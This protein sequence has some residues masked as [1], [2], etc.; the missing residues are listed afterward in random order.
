MTDKLKRIY[1]FCKIW[2]ASIIIAGALVCTLLAKLYWAIHL[3]R[4]D[5]YPGWI[6]ADIPVLLGAELLCSLVC[7]FW[8]KNWAARSSFIFAA[9]ICTW[10]VINAGWLIATGT[11]VL[12]AVLAPLFFDPLGRFAIIGNHLAGKPL[13][14]AALLVPSGI[15]LTFFFSVLIKPAMPQLTK[16]H[17]QIRLA[18]YVILLLISGVTAK[19]S[20]LNTDSK[21]FAELR[22]NSQFKAVKSIFVNGRKNKNNGNSAEKIRTALPAYE[23]PLP[24]RTDKYAGKYNVVIVVLESI[25]PGQAKIFN[26]NGA[27]VPFLSKMARR[28]FAFTNC[29]TVA[30]HTTKALFAIHTGL[31]PSTSQ[32]YIEA[33]VQEKNYQSIATILKTAGYRTAFFQSAEGAF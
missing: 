6:V 20:Q 28:G 5:L 27:N 13:I 3:G 8:Q 22:Y 32:D 31:Y 17:I 14:A 30:T 19:I 26:H 4:V 1:A 10:S 16:K 12:P 21:I 18:V 23:K 9:L 7:F 33:A 2:A 11:Q 15:A 24:L 29:R 25:S